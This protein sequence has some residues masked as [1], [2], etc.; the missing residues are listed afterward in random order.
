MVATDNIDVLR[1]NGFELDIDEKALSGSRLM[2]T[3]QPVNKSTVFDLKG[4]SDFHPFI[5][6]LG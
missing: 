6:L 4:N 5:E 3:A 1:K 2:L